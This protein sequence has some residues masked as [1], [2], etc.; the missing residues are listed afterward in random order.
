M[1]AQWKPQWCRELGRFLFCLGFF[2]WRKP[3]LNH[4]TLLGK[5]VRRNRGTHS[6]D[7]RIA[8]TSWEITVVRSTGGQQPALCSPPKPGNA[9]LLQGATS[10]PGALQSQGRKTP[11]PPHC[12]SSAFLPH[13]LLSQPLLQAHLLLLIKKSSLHKLTL[14]VARL[15][16]GTA[17]LSLWVCLYI[18]HLVFHGLSSFHYVHRPRLS[19]SS[20][21]AGTTLGHSLFCSGTRLAS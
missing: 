3:S 21:I 13:A 5:V 16:L 20:G 1:R 2:S 9:V 14:I 7:W 17:G 6:P 15:G 18:Q 10:S 12:S 11:S 4:L 19:P 8:K